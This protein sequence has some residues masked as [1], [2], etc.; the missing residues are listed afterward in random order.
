MEHTTESQIVLQ[1]Q[2]QFRRYPPIV[3]LSYITGSRLSLKMLRRPLPLLSLICAA[4][5]TA[6]IVLGF[7]SNIWIGEIA[8]S[9][10]PYYS[11]LLLIA[12]SVLFAA[13][14][15]APA[16]AFVL[17]AL[18]NALT[19]CPL[20]LRVLAQ[21]AATAL[22]IRVMQVNVCN[23]NRQFAKLSE[24]INKTQP[25]LIA[26]EEYTPDC[27]RELSAALAPYQFRIC[28]PQQ[29]YYGIAI[30]SKSQIVA[31][32]LFVPQVAGPY[33]PAI[34]CTVRKNERL[35]RVAA[36]HVF[37]PQHPKAKE[38]RDQQLS[39]LAARLKPVDM[40]TVIL[41]DMNTTPWS[42]AYKQFLN[43]VNLK[44]AQIGFGFQP[45]CSLRGILWVPIDYCLV[46]NHATVLSY[47]VGPQFGS[48][49]SPVVADL[50]L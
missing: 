10:L 20:F 7:F 49:H 25:D 30:Y 36:M 4:I 45:T 8:C 35:F 41:A 50:K 38:L 23:D 9:F 40:P 29:T 34:I 28:K 31:S 44:D 15:R 12:A 3:N 39:Q 24:Y 42:S 33:E 26:I 11:A 43:T 5:V 37:S 18:L 16:I 32:D 13:K 46:P 21:P 48:D 27:E 47:T 1:K 14:I 19:F 6:L 17:V 22:G 2:P